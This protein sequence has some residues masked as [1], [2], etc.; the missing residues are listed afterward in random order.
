MKRLLIIVLGWAAL[1]LPAA[2]TVKQVG[3]QLTLANGQLRVM[4]DLSRG[5]RVG[6][7]VY[8]G[9]NDEELIFD[10]RLSNGGLFKD[11]W[12]IQGW[13]GE[14][15]RRRYS[16]K[17]E[18]S[19]PNE[20]VI[21]TWTTST[22]VYRG[23]K[24]AD[25]ADILLEKT[26]R[27]KKGERILT[28]DY[29]FTN[30]GKQGKRAGFWSQAAIDFD[31]THK[32]N[33]YW[34]PTRYGVDWIDLP[35]STSANGYWYIAPPVAGWNGVTN[36]KMKRGMVFLMNYN[37]L[38]QFYDNAAANTVEWMYD[39]VAIPP[40]KTWRTRI[41][42]IPTEG[43]SGY[44]YADPQLVADCRAEGTA[45]GVRLTHTL[46]AATQ[47]LHE[48]ELVAAV[49]G[50]SSKWRV[51]S[52]PV[53]IG[54]LGLEPKVV[55]TD[56]A[57]T[58]AF[59]C[60][61]KMDVTGKATDGTPVRIHYE[62][63]FGGDAGRNKD[64]VL[65][66]PLHAFPAP[67][68]RKIY[69]KPDQIRLAR[70]KVPRILFVRGLWAEY[71]GIDPALK[72]LGKVEVVNAWM[73]KTALGETLGNF[74]GSYG[75]LLKYDGI[76]LGNVSGA[77]LA[78]IGQE[79]LSDFIRAGG[80]VLLLGGDRTYGQTHFSNPR[81]AELL[82]VTFQGYGDYGRLKDGFVPL[83]RGGAGHPVL[84]GVSFS[85]KCVVGYAHRLTPKPDSVV[86]VTFG[87][88][89]PALVLSGD[90]RYRVGVVALLP[91]GT[92]PS[93]KIA[94]RDAAGWQKVMANTLSW[95]IH[96]PETETQQQQKERKK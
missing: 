69:L 60:V 64:Q 59:P 10:Y 57:G 70:Q 23:Q 72:Q 92:P 44:V 42:L 14:F 39:D 71:N 52:A 6:G 84:K 13:P 63:Y 17:I 35:H 32:N 45:A 18:K 37:D 49:E 16:V 96:R 33:I 2:V 8:K 73:K 74:P 31:G 77:M 27:L 19:G 4:I 11:L 89:Q 50:I 61:L 62:N 81:F 58:G 56:L 15:N 51:Q 94:Y 80:G 82:P 34:R 21:K 66:E 67:P 29:A 65:L 79:M 26:F 86:A 24:K 46:T 38:R 20:A 36:S 76:I 30:Q 7:Y 3:D 75:N 95:L 91:F 25:I 5:A 88:Q 54:Q 83:A 68:K 12:A 53:K 78:D 55:T 48:V 90:P 28:V 1:N 47:P 9:F 85:S 41:Q 43:F 22:G 93:G 87:K 40:G